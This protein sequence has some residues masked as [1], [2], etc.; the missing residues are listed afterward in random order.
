MTRVGTTRTQPAEMRTV[1]A[2]AGRSAMTTRLRLATLQP[3]DYVLAY[4]ARASKR[5]VKREVLFTV[6]ND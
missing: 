5:I 1:S 6:T 3:G 2:V 4:E